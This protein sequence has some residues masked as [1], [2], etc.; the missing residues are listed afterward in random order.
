MSCYLY[1]FGSFG[2]LIIL[3]SL[4]SDSGWERETGGS[5]RAGGGSLL[6][7]PDTS[8]AGPLEVRGILTQ[9]L[10]VWQTTLISVQEQ[11]RSSFNMIDTCHEY[12]LRHLLYQNSSSY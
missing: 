10:C 5:V 6:S 9:T 12:T 8:Q 1:F 3:W 4:W 2:D 11:T 7:G